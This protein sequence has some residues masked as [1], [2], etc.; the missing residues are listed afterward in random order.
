MR[1][2]LS[3]AELEATQRIQILFPRGMTDEVLRVIN[4]ASAEMLKFGILAMIK[5]LTGSAGGATEQE[6]VPE[7]LLKLVRTV[8]VPAIAEFRAADKFRPGET[9]DGVKI[10]RSMGDNFRTHFLPKI[11]RSVLTIEI[12]VSKL[13][14]GSLDA[15][16]LAGIDREKR[17]ITLGQLWE[18]LKLQGGGQ[19]GALL[20]NGW[21]NIFYILDI[22]GNLWAVSALWYGDGWALYADS[23]GSPREWDADDR[24]CSR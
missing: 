18:I 2:G 21:A 6:P 24:I 16:I 10:S 14:E 8:P 13:L 20:T 7:K 15:D 19:K 17:V 11:E 9:V 23:V 4:G 12:K 3:P 22:H 1:Q 5:S